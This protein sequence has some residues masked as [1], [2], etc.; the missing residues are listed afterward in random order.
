M[1]TKLHLFP[2][3]LC[4]LL[5]GF[6]PAQ[7]N[8]T[9]SAQLDINNVNATVN[10]GNLWLDGYESS[11]IVPKGDTLK[12]SSLRVGALWMGGYVPNGDLKTAV[13]TYEGNGNRNYWAGPLDPETGAT[14]DVAM[15]NW[16]RMFEI[17]SLEIIPH[18]QDFLLDGTI[19]NVVADNILG[20]P[21]R[22]NPE[23]LEVHGFELPDQDLA[24]FIDRNGNGKY[25]P[26]SGDYPLMKGHKAIWWVFNDMGG[27]PKFDPEDGNIG[28][29]VQCM[30]FAYYSNDQCIDNSTFYDF[31]LINRSSTAIDSFYTSLWLDGDLGCYK[32][33]YL[34]SAPA[35]NLFYLYNADD[36][37]DLE[38]C[39]ASGYGTEIPVIGIRVLKGLEDSAGNGPGLSSVMH[40]IADGSADPPSAMMGPSDAEQ[41][42]NYMNAC[43]RDGSPLTFGDDGYGGTEPYSYA[44]DG[45]PIND[46][47]N[48][49]MCEISISEWNRLTFL[50]SGSITFHPGTER[51]LSY[52][53]IWD[54]MA[55][56]PCPDLTDFFAKT[57]DI[58]DFYESI[59]PGE[60]SDVEEVNLN[61][62]F[63]RV[64][65]NPASDKVSILSQEN[66]QGIEF[67]DI[68]GRLWHR[69]SGINNAQLEI[70]VSDWPSGIYFYRIIGK[71]GEVQV[72]ELVR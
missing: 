34:G 59:G 11:Y 8:W 1:K 13:A 55:D 68:H 67:Y 17:Y 12:K 64:F 61:Q 56:Y 36:F 60:F 15:L 42:Y 35:R 27:I 54:D 37:D 5:P 21:G 47:T 24:P 30:A 50:N 9:A 6:L 28:I 53:V 18:I 62:H 2:I 63:A 57:D 58:S 72:G 45:S 70:P 39:F 48:W 26:Y 19:D 69:E 7:I 49:S 16:D 32:D 31:T 4:I 66:V 20:W 23:F 52:A 44:F 71:G 25:E 14:N 10:I 40:Y 38:N 51:Y 22:G 46:S 43:W 65:P 29:E 3:L 41:A 33:D